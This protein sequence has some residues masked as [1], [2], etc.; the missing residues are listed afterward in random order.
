LGN[1][2][3]FQRDL[4]RPRES[5][6]NVLFRFLHARSGQWRCRGVLSPANAV[7]AVRRNDSE[8]PHVLSLV[9]KR[10][11]VSKT[12]RIVIS[13]PEPRRQFPDL[14]QLLW[15][16]AMGMVL[17]IL[18]AGILLVAHATHVV[19]WPISVLARFIFLVSVGLSFGLGAM[20]TGAMFMVSGE[21]G[22]AVERKSRFNSDSVTRKHWQTR[23]AANHGKPFRTS[24]GWAV[25]IVVITIVILTVEGSVQS[26]SHI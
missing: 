16:G 25:G 15:H 7:A 17:G 10:T 22:S 13:M 12:R 5:F 21:P 4:T 8:N 24:P 3:Y 6:F 11:E 23:T 14:Y 20:L 19:G 1:G 2:D 18:C 9:Q 26:F